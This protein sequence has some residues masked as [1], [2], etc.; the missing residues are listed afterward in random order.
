M[1]IKHHHSVIFHEFL[2]PSSQR[3]QIF[4]SLM[5]LVIIL[6]LFEIMDCQF[7]FFLRSC[8]WDI[9]LLI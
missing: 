6:I 2:S 4:R 1:C 8:F 5:I 3:K 9:E 7:S